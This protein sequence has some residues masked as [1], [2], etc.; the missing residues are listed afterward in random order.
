MI[1]ANEKWQNWKKF[2]EKAFLNQENKNASKHPSVTLSACFLLL[3]HPPPPPKHICMTKKNNLYKQK[4]STDKASL[5]VKPLKHFITHS[6]RAN[7][8]LLQPDLLDPQLLTLAKTQGH[9]TEVVLGRARGTHQRCWYKRDS[10]LE[11]MRQRR[12]KSFEVVWGVTYL[13]L[14]IRCQRSGPTGTSPP[15]VWVGQE[16]P[17]QWGD[18]LRARGSWNHYTAIP[19]K[20]RALLVCSF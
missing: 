19:S 15:E 7:C 4:I 13:E 9:R 12:L 18:Q 14:S 10:G 3:Q 8:F 1:P 17:S 20:L 2:T 16:G 6:G 11:T 5:Y